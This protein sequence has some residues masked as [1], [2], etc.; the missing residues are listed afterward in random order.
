MFMSNKLDFHNPPGVNPLRDE[1]RMPVMR[2]VSGDS[3]QVDARLAAADGGPATPK[4]SH[5]EFVLSENQFSPALWTG[6]WGRG[7]L[8]DGNSPGLVHVAIP[9]DVT[10]AL[11][12]GSYM[13]SMRV[14]DL[15][16]YSFSTQLKGNFLVEYLPT[17]DQHS[18]PYRDGTSEI[19]GG[20][21]GDA[22]SGSSSQEP[23]RTETY[24]FNPR[25][26][27]YHLITAVTDDDGNLTLDVSKK[28]VS[29]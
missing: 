28:G 7:V 15:M 11:R 22:T 12:R 9:R 25:T 21:A 24:A 23:S 4:N 5:V 16:K 29:L 3:W 6:E 10:K 18:I 8:P 27:K 13:F 14:S 2:V 19:F 17:S 20:S 26:G 1:D